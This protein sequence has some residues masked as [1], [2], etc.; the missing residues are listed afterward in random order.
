MKNT[1]LVVLIMSLCYDHTQAQRTP[2][3]APE[4]IKYQGTYHN[5]PVG[6]EHVSTNTLADGVVTT[7]KLTNDIIASGNMADGTVTSDKLAGDI[8]NSLNELENALATNK[9]APKLIP[10][11]L[12]LNKSVAINQ[13]AYACYMQRMLP[14][15]WQSP[16]PR[17]TYNRI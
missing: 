16:K 11:S 6:K 5:Q 13:H 3:H 2:S 12:S 15:A 17:P 1:L 10:V 7:D 8:I 9:Q 14:F 4:F